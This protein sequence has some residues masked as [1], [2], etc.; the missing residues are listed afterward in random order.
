M[1][2]FSNY[3]NQ[4]RLGFWLIQLVQIGA[5]NGDDAFVS[6]GVFAE[7]ILLDIVIVEEPIALPSL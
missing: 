6:L 1:C 4:G 3:P 7:N 2:V 5:Q